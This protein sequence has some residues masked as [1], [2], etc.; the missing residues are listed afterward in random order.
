VDRQDS[1]PDIL[2]PLCNLIHLDLSLHKYQDFLPLL[3]NLSDQALKLCE[4]VYL[5]N[6]PDLL[7]HRVHS[8]TNTPDRQEL[9]IRLQEVFRQHLDKRREGCTEHT[10]LDTLV[11]R[12]LLLDIFKLW[13]KPDIKHPIGLVDDKVFYE[14]EA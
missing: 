6:L 14:A 8:A 5:I 7:L 4:L 1:Q 13:E 9:V 10:G 3:L 2:K 12:Q 11:R